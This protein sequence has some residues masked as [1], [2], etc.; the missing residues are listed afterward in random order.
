MFS[1]YSNVPR[2]KKPGSWFLPAKCV[3][4]HLCNSKI[5]SKDDLH[6]YL[7]CHSSTG[8]FS[9]HFANKHQVSGFPINGALAGNGLMSVWKDLL[10]KMWT[11]L[12]PVNCFASQIIWLASV[13]Y[14]FLLKVVSEQTTVAFLMFQ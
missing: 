1:H 12:K 13:W 9:T 4:K 6:L 7:K 14:E 5:L 8:V 10:L 3:K 2:M 11:V